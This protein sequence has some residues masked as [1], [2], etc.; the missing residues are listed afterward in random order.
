VSGETGFGI[1][2]INF[3][4]LPNQNGHF[5][6]TR[7][8]VGCVTNLR[9]GNSF[10]DIQ[11]N[12]NLRNNLT[13]ITETKRRTLMIAIGMVAPVAGIFFLNGFG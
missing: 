4:R 3:R 1:L 2:A 6:Q 5:G 8:Y 11:R 7:L 13:T 10:M 12:R 9:C